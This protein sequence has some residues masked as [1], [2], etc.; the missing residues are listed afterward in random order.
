MSQRRFQDKDAV[1]LPGQP[2]D[3]RR[4]FFAPDLLVGVH[5]EDGAYRRLQAY[6]VQGAEGE[7]HLGQPCLHIEY[8]GSRQTG[9]SPYHR[10][11]RQRP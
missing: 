7:D 2:D 1:C 6:I 9:L 3:V 4:R 8:T 10:H 5:E 11:L